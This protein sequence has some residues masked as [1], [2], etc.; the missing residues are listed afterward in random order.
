VRPFKKGPEVYIRADFR[1]KEEDQLRHF[2]S[3]KIPPNEE[4]LGK[5]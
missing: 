4:Q 3:W 5:R 2:A 1:R